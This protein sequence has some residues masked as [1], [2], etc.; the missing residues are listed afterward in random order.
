MPYKTWLKV[1]KYKYTGTENRPTLVIL[2]IDRDQ[3]IW[4]WDDET[5]LR[6]MSVNRAEMDLRKDYSY[7]AP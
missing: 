1:G 2:D 5:K 7:I 4:R 3:V 6:Y